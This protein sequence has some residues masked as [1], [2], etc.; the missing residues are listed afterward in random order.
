M[1]NF[2]VGNAKKINNIFLV[3]SNKIFTG[4]YLN[5]KRCWANQIFVDS[6]KHFSGCINRVHGNQ[7]STKSFPFTEMFGPN[8]SEC[9]EEIYQVY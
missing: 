5:E 8:S 9:F 2:S 4:P 1:Q 3:N 6:T 7:K